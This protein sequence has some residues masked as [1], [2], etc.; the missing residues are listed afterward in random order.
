MQYIIRKK[1]FLFDNSTF[2]PTPCLA[3]VHSIYSKKKD[4]E[5]AKLELEREAFKEGIGF[6]K[7]Q[8]NPLLYHEVA[9]Y[10]EKKFNINIWTN[11]E[12]T[13][14]LP[15]FK[16][17]EFIS[18][19]DLLEVMSFLGENFFE[20]VEKDKIAIFYCPEV[21]SA[22]LTKYFPKGLSKDLVE[23]LSRILFHITEYEFGYIMFNTMEDAF[24]Y[25]LYSLVEN[26]KKKTLPE[27]ELNDFIKIIENYQL[28]REDRSILISE[29]EKDNLIKLVQDLELLRITEHE[30]W[31]TMYESLEECEEEIIAYYN[32]D[33]SYQRLALFFGIPDFLI[34]MKL[35]GELDEEE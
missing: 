29:E 24:Q 18:D 10:F 11:E 12:K 5:K 1:I 13:E 21:N 27:S 17:P 32:Y 15:L 3:G 30:L 35:K 26:F 14:L 31:D 28:N 6:S 2:Y 20:I 22:S 8:E 4:A 7:I 33:Y 34:E 23:D 16:L 25:G 19:E 9:N